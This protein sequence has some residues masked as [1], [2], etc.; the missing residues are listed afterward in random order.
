VV[1]LAVLLTI[2]ILLGGLAPTFAPETTKTVKEI[3]NGGKLGT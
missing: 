1:F 3:L 2:F